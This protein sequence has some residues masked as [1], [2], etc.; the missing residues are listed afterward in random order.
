MRAAWDAGRDRGA[1][2]SPPRTRTDEGLPYR[3]ASALGFVCLVGLA[4]ALARVPPAFA[5]AGGVHRAQLRA[6]ATQIHRMSPPGPGPS[7][8]FVG[9]AG[10]GEQRV[11]RREAELARSVLGAHFGARSRA[12]ELVNDIHDRRTYPLA[13]QSNLRETLRLIGRRMNREQDALVLM[14]TSHG[15]PQEG[16][17]LTNGRLIDDALTP[18]ALRQALDEAGIRWRIVVVSACYAGIFIPALKSSRTLVITAADAR[19]SSFGCADDRDLTY[20]GEALL[21]DTLPRTCSIENAFAAAR[22]V[23]D[24]RESAEGEIHSHPQIY[25]GE[26]MKRKLRQIE[27]APGTGRCS[28]GKLAGAKESH[29]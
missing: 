10:Y 9:F 25:V 23:I 19:H 5:T 28:P 14:L 3:R 1:V 13:T 29:R 27:P 7:V 2:G 17:A 24:R 6:V 16:L 4:A 26:Q 22:R 11:F 12:V 21:E 8:Y 18:E 20:F 15:S